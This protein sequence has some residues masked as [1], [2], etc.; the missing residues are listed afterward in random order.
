MFIKVDLQAG[1]LITG[2]SSFNVSNRHRTIRDGTRKLNEVVNSVPD[3]KP[4]D[5]VPFPK[6]MWKIT[7]ILWQQDE[8]FNASIF[9]PVKIVTNAHRPVKIWELDSKGNYLRETEEEVEDYGYLLHYSESSTTVGCIRIESPEAAITIGSLIET[10][11]KH[12]E[13]IFLEVY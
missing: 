9:G 13:E 2:G 12:K 5:P 10:A 1:K 6:G 11:L 3:K 8:K 4:Y 7:H